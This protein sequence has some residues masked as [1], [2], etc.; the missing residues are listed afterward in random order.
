MQDE[1]NMKQEQRNTDGATG[2]SF[3]EGMPDMLERGPF[4]ASSDGWEK[5]CDW[6]D[7]QL[8]PPVVLGGASV[9]KQNTFD[10][11][12]AYA[13]SSGRVAEEVKVAGSQSERRVPSAAQES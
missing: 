9:Q 3:F 5:R 11:N 1:K 10:D 4:G 8:G 6:R 7:G 12:S 13:R 2:K